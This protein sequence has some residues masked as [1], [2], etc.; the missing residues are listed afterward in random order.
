MTR[1]SLTKIEV[2]S[3]RDVEV[4]AMRPGQVDDVGHVD[5]DNAATA[6]GTG[7]PVRWTFRLPPQ[8]PMV[9]SW[10]KGGAPP[11]DQLGPVRR[12]RSSE[13]NRHVPVTAY[14][15]TNGDYVSLE[16]GLE[17][18]LLR[19]LDRDPSVLRIVAQPLT[20][21]WRG[22]EPGSH[23][24][25][26]LTVHAGAAPTV[27]DVRAVDKQDQ[28]FE[29]TSTLTRQACTSVG[30]SYQVF[31]GM[32]DLERLNM[33]WLNGF[34]RAPPWASRHEGAILAAA[35]RDG[36]TMASV[37]AHDDGSGESISTVW[38][39]LWRGVLDVDVTAPWTPATGVTLGIGAHR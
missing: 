19:R 7:M 5:G 23:T 11:L 37:F 33:M 35:G 27:W 39:L 30:W 34:R 12:P 26:L 8:P 3:T 36:A 32:N 29:T 6:S 15:M 2:L 10:P 9:W 38:H 25:D 21:S 28:H 1:W 14:T 22:S 24:P 20:L 17:H 4:E 13:H 16:S 18:D 31:A